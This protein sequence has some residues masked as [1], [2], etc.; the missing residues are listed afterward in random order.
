LTIFAV[1]ACDLF[2]F[3]AL[4]LYRFHRCGFLARH[5]CTLWW[6]SGALE[7]AACPLRS[8]S[9]RVICSSEQPLSA[10]SH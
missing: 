7:L 9:D 4:S 10:T 2:G 6:S 5:S 1:E 8:E 3:T